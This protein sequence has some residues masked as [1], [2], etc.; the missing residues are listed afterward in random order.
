MI[1]RLTNRERNRRQ[2]VDAQWQHALE[3]MRER[4]SP[5]AT[6]LELEM[7]AVRAHSIFSS[8]VAKCR[9]SE[10]AVLSYEGADS[11]VVRL[12]WRQPDYWIK[13]VYNPGNRVL[14][15]VLPNDPA[16]SWHKWSARLDT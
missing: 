12:T 15:T 3:R 11:V 6:Q 14:R 5:D 4:H 2:R 1:E 13:V 10:G 9:T 7:L 8:W 16:P